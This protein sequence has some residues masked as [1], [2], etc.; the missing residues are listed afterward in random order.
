MRDMSDN[1]K[2]VEPGEWVELPKPPVLEDGIPV[3]VFAQENK[4]NDGQVVG[5]VDY[6]D[7]V[8]KVS[9]QTVRNSDASAR[10]HFRKLW[11][12]TALPQEVWADTREG[13]AM[14]QYLARF[15]DGYFGITVLDGEALW[16]YFGSENILADKRKGILLYQA[17]VETEHSGA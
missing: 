8:I 4:V 1:Y 14:L 16:F 3:V 11:M 5:L 12:A 6:E 7:E 9:T 17:K 2:L 15:E 13:E 10:P